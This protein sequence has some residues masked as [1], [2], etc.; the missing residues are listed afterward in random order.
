MNDLHDVLDRRRRELHPDPAGFDRLLRLRRRRQQ[1]RRVGAAVIVLL[2]LIP[3]GLVVRSLSDLGS[4]PVPAD[5]EQD[6]RVGRTIEA[7]T[8]PLAGIASLDGNLWVGTGA[9]PGVRRIDTATGTVTAEIVTTRPPE[10]GALGHRLVADVIASAGSI[11]VVNEHESTISRIEPTNGRVI[12]TI[13][14]GP[15]PV[16][17]TEAAGSVWVMSY[18]AMHRIDPS[19]NEM[20]ATIPLSMGGESAQLAGGSS[21]V[22]MVTPGT[23]GAVAGP[24]SRLLRID[25]E[26]HRVMSD[27]RVASRATGIAVDDHLWVTDQAAGTLLRVDPAT[28]ELLATIPVGEAPSAVAIEDGTV[29]VTDARDQTIRAIDLAENRVAF[30]LPGGRGASGVARSDSSLWVLNQVDATITEIRPNG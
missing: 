19:T 21:H 5:A 12:A 23:T 27:V 3:T 11:W 22:W 6:A 24:D 15:Y 26:T 16:A 7:G 14:T 29:W 20:V 30:T 10:G 25:V 28:G 18:E 4:A 17:A 13:P 8:G 1:Q 9:I 2:V